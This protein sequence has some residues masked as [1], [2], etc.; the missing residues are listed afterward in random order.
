M[1]GRRPGLS[2][3]S[4]LDVLPLP[5]MRRRIEV[6]MTEQILPPLPNR[7]VGDRWVAMTAGGSR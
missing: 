1:N 5:R 4:P 6:N 2:L 7:C 3:G